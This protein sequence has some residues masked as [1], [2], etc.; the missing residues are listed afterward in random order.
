MPTC[1]ATFKDKQS[2]NELIE[3]LIKS[4]PKGMKCQLIKPE[5]YLE[6]ENELENQNSIEAA[7]GLSAEIVSPVAFK[8]VEI[9]NPKIAR[10][11]RQLLMAFWLMPFGF[12][13]GLTFTKMTGLQTFSDWGISK[14][15]EP[16]FGA[17]LGMG[18]GW[19][20]SHAAAS[21]VNTDQIDDI[22]ALNKLNKEGLWILI[23][24]IHPEIDLPWNLI[25]QSSP[26][27]II[28][29]KDL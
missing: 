25:N 2:A 26:I 16:V 22:K 18:S 13:A 3:L 15:L 21:S 1:V 7:K 9:L 5:D 4:L 20:G 29:L 10:K 6:K 28:T 14:T 8:S 27:K 12:L 23:V 24:E 19:I 11:K 17:F